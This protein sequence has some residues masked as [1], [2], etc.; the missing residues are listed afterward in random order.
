[1][2]ESSLNSFRALALVVIST[3]G[4]LLVGEGGLQAYYYLENGKWLW[5]NTAFRIGYTQPLEDRRQ[6]G[7]RPLFQ[8]RE[9]GISIDQRGFRKTFPGGGE[10]ERVIVCLGDS[11]PFGAGVWDEETYASYLAKELRAKGL[12]ITVMNAG[13]PSYNLRQ[14]FDRLRKDVLP[15][16]PPDRIAL[17]TVEAAN[18]I[19]LLTHYGAEWNPDLTWAQVRWSHTWDSTIG[20]QRFAI[21]YYSTRAAAALFRKQNSEVPDTTHSANDHEKA[22]EMLQNV[23]LVLV[24]QLRFLSGHSI[25]VVLLPINPFYYQLAGQE[26]NAGLKNWKAMQVYVQDWDELIRKYN[27][28]LHSVAQETNNAYF[29]DLRESMDAKDR[30]RLYIDY[31]HHSPEGNRLVANDLLDFVLK[32]HLLQKDG[33]HV[34]VNGERTEVN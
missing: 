1:M 11:V 17:I 7:L 12:A 24:E 3:V 25:P 2:P 23:R 15:Y 33:S 14:S 30:D 9:A 13:I 27:E 21:I 34:R 29:L 6:Y 18:D 10:Q 31:I 32:H 22:G 16:Y 20:L 19:S 28:V 8:D 5:Q 26:K 4:A